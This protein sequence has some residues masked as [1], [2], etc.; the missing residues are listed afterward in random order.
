MF[1]LASFVSVE[2]RKVT[3][4]TYLALRPVANES[5]VLGMLKCLF[6]KKGE[7]NVL[8]NGMCFGRHTNYNVR[9]VCGVC[10]FVCLF[11]SVGTQQVDASSRSF[12]SGDFFDKRR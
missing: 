9:S 1:V 12:K 7:W 3:T 4:K 5:F 2:H 8:C 10:L 11:V 6:L